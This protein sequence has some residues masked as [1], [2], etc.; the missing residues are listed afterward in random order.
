MRI[1]VLLDVMK[2][3]KRMKK[4]KWPGGESNVIK[5]KYERL[6][7]FSYFCGMLGHIEDYCEKLYSVDSDD[8]TRFWGPERRVEKKRNNGDGA[9]RLRDGGIT[10]IAPAS[11]TVTKCNGNSQNSGTLMNLLRNPNLMRQSNVVNVAVATPMI[12]TQEDQLM[13]E[14]TYEIIANNQNPLA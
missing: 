11:V 2:P 10:I 3:L 7:N 8:G 4:I 6:G 13:D 1:H 12:Q 5:F 14:N 9:S